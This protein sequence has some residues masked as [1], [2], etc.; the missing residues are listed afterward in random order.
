M[1]LARC[2]VTTCWTYIYAGFPFFSELHFLLSINNSCD[3]VFLKSLVAHTLYFLDPHSSL[4]LSQHVAIL[5]YTVT[6]EYIL[7]NRPR[8]SNVHS[9]SILQCTP[10][11]HI[12]S[13][14]TDFPIN[15][16]FATVSKQSTR[17][18][19]L[20]ALD[21]MALITCFIS[22]GLYISA[23]WVCGSYPGLVP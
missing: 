17:H 20:V 3:R 23:E 4:L 7:Y 21:L 15:F 1:Q 22:M 16:V 12:W 5:T 18:F 9:I 13:L 14:A 2:F 8:F 10:V 11:S 6:F 19:S